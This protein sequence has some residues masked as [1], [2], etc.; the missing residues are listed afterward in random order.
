MQKTSKIV[1]YVCT[2]MAEDEQEIYILNG[3]LRAEA[4]QNLIPMI[5]EQKNAYFTDFVEY[6]SADGVFYML[7]RY[8]KGVP[9]L[10]KVKYM[11]MEQR[12][13]YTRLLIEQMVLQ[14]MPLVFQYAVLLPDLILITEKKQVHFCY[15][16]PET[17]GQEPVCFH[18]VELR[19]LELVKRLL[20]HELEMRYSDNLLNF[21]QALQKGDVYFDYATLYAS[22]SVINQ[23]LN[24]QKD[25]LISRKYRFQLWE[26]CKKHGRKIRRCLLFLIIAVSAGVL[27]YEHFGK[28]KQSESEIQLT[29]IGTL[30]I[31]ENQPVITTTVTSDD[32]VTTGDTV[33]TTN[34]E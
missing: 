8:Q 1:T 6:F 27:L 34:S 29:Q 18:D 4:Y 9:L 5:L 3:F 30:V 14:D 2:D 10:Q 32:A 7:F 13:E 24:A 16:L 15:Q 31:R 22:F 26:S 19:L 21:C 33:T 17:L 12:L 20:Y 23:E 25:H 28:I 11:D